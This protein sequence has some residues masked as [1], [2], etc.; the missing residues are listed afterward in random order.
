MGMGMVQA[1]SVDV[2]TPAD[3]TAKLAHDA[4]F[5]DA[6]T[7]VAYLRGDPELPLYCIRF[8][9]LDGPDPRDELA[10]T[11]SLSSE[12]SAA[13]AAK[14]ARMDA[15][16]KRGPWTSAVLAQIADRPGVVSTELAE[17]LGWERADFKLHVRRLKELGL[18]ISLDVGYRLS[19]RGRAYLTISSGRQPRSLNNPPQGRR[20]R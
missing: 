17:T 10:A 8:R 4:G 12:E 20:G 15:A 19:P 1:E 6:A 3:I 16:S 2:I 7:A 5:A 11:A 18:T 13:I 9:R 14:L